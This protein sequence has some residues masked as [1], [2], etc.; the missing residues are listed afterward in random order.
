M[1][2]RSSMT[3]SVSLLVLQPPRVVPGLA[4]PAADGQ[5]GHRADAAHLQPPGG[6]RREAWHHRAVEPA[7]EA[8]GVTSVGHPAGDERVV[9]HHHVL[10]DRLA[11]RRGNRRLPRVGGGMPQVD[12]H[13]PE[14]RRDQRPERGGGRRAAVR[15][16]AEPER[17]YP[18]PGPRRRVRLGGG[19]PPSLSGRRPTV[20]RRRRGGAGDRASA[21]RTPARPAGVRRRRRRVR[22]GPLGGRRARP[23]L[24]P[25]ARTGL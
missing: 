15:R 10:E 5:G 4:V 2:A 14:P 20:G 7:I 3:F 21:C 16:G 11:G 22:A 17:P 8:Q 18:R 19:R 6:R 25:R 9:H 24:R 13:R 23:G 1:S 12:G